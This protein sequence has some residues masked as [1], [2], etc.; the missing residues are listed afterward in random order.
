MNFIDR[1]S[2]WMLTTKSRTASGAVA[3]VTPMAVLDVVGD[4]DRRRRRSRDDF[5]FLSHSVARCH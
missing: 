4:G 3:L 2:V 1:A 5:Y